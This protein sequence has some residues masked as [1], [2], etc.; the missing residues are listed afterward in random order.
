[1]KRNI[2]SPFRRQRPFDTVQAASIQVPKS[3][4]LWLSLTNKE[5]GKKAVRIDEY[6]EIRQS[7]QGDSDAYRRLIE[8]HQAHVSKL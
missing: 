8:R 1:M 4:V 6:N 3:W 7:K 5:S 2:L